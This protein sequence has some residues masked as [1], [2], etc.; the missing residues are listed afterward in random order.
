MKTKKAQMNLGSAPGIV[1]IVGLTFL[2]MA[3]MAFIGQKYGASMPTDKSA[4]STN[5]SV[6]Q[7]E[8]IAVSYLDNASLCNAENFAI[9]NIFNGTTA[10][11]IN[12]AN[13]TL[14]STGTLT[15][16]TSE[17]A[18]AP[19]L[20][21]YTTEY[22]GVGCDVNADLETEI[23]NNTSIAGIILTISLVGIV[24]TILMGVFLGLRTPRL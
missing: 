1:L 20:V 13:Y 11:V 15:N 9:S 22:A 21:T 6:S 4:T 24:L 18:D 12:S 8:L 5:E 19:W 14:T 16:L 2:V 23:S 7:T 3:T 17:Y 10:I